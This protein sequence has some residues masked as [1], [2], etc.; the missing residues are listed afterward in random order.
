MAPAHP[1]KVVKEWLG[2]DMQFWPKHF[3]PP[4]SPD[5]NPL[6]YSMWVQ[7]EGKP[8]TT[9]HSNVDALKSSVNRA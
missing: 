8:C 9:R 2:L 5:L 1:A 3:W 4:Q 7:I 6:D